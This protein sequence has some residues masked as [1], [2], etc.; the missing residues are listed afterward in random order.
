MSLKFLCSGR[1]SPN[2][3]LHASFS[4]RFCYRRIDKKAQL[5]Q[6]LRATVPPSS[7]PEI[8]PFTPPTLK[9]LAY[10]TKYVVDQMHRLQDIR[11]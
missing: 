3:E 2:V 8:L 6:G 7:E 9:T 11:R 4:W 5:T 10:R 1:Y